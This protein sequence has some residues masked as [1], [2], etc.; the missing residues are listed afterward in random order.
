MCFCSKSE[1]IKNYRFIAS[2][3]GVPKNYRFS[4]SKCGTKKLTIC[5]LKR[6]AFEAGNVHLYDN[7]DPFGVDYEY[8]FINQLFRFAQPCTEIPGYR[9]P[10]VD[11]LAIISSSFQVKGEFL[12]PMLVWA[13]LDGTLPVL[14]RVDPYSVNPVTIADNSACK[15]YKICVRPIL[16]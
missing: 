10:A 16:V 6:A 3:W 14:V 13:T 12:C 5:K 4:T 11:E 9:I 8:Y 1:D 15:G 2:E 7:P